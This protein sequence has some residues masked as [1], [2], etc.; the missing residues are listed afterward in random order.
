VITDWWQE[1]NMDVNYYKGFMDGSLQ[2]K[3]WEVKQ[4]PIKDI[5]PWITEHKI[6]NVL[7]VEGE[8]EK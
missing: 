8:H 6:L 4:M 5:F 2:G 7:I 1:G 3:K